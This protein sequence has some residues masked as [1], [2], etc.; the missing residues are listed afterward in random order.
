MG[1]RL[2]LILRPSPLPDR[3]MVRTGRVSGMVD[4]RL[5]IDGVKALRWGYNLLDSLCPPEL[6]VSGACTAPWY[7]PAVEG[8]ILRGAGA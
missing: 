4:W 8:V 2:G 5:K 6:M 3:Q 1:A 7:A